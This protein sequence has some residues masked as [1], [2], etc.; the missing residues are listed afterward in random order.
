MVAGGI[1]GDAARPVQLGGCGRTAIAAKTEGPVSG[2]GGDYSTRDLAD[3]VVALVG[4]VDVSGSVHGDPIGHV[5]LGAGGRA[6]IATVP[7]VPLPAIVVITPFETLR[8]RRLTV[9]AI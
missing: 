6:A 8:M 4:N 7:Y 1:H 9:S 3:A 2:Y 5:Q